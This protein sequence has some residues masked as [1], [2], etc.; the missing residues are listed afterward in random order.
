MTGL[1]TLSGLF[2]Y[3]AWHLNSKIYV[4]SFN[5]I[6]LCFQYFLWTLIHLKIHTYLTF[7]F[8][9]N[10]LLNCFNSSWW[11]QNNSGE[12]SIFEQLTF[13]QLQ[14]LQFEGKNGNP[15]NLSDSRIFQGLIILVLMIMDRFL[16][17]E[18]QYR[19]RLKGRTNLSWYIIFHWQL[20]RERDWG[21]AAS[22]ILFLLFVLLLT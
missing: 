22:L 7:V 16:A 3:S 6:S 8:I 11:C 2:S 21:T 17:S 10:R 5:D 19:K 18:L 4:L 13:Q 9:F 1:I 20:I 14:V 12:W 15:V